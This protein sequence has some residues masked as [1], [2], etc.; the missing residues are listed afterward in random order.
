MSVAFEEGKKWKWG[1]VSEKII[2][3]TINYHEEIGWGKTYPTLVGDGNP[4]CASF[5]NYCLQQVDVTSTRNPGAQSF[6]K[7]DNFQQIP[8]PILGA[9]IVYKESNHV[10]FIYAR[11]KDGDLGILGRNQ[12]DSITITSNKKFLKSK[13]L[14]G[15]DVP[16]VYY[17]HAIKI[18]DKRGIWIPQY[19]QVLV[20][21]TKH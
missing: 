18:C 17:S 13:K 9:I 1:G 10:G 7:N 12:S 20:S 21:L 8:I 14:V 16:N 6:T 11:T 19:I 2:T 5:V 3:K 15:Y 4:W